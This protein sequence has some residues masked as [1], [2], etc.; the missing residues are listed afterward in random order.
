MAEVKDNKGGITSVLTDK[1]VCKL[2]K[3]S[4]PNEFLQIKRNGILFVN[5]FSVFRNCP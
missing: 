1:T 2:K 3:S 5:A 4:F